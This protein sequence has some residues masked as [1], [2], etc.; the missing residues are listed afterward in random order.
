MLYI[1]YD[2]VRVVTVY[3][4]SFVISYTDTNVDVVPAKGGVETIHF[5]S[6]CKLLRDDD[7]DCCGMLQWKGIDTTVLD[8]AILESYLR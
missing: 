5:G 4:A 8:D 7:A 2:N 3:D 1:F 6:K